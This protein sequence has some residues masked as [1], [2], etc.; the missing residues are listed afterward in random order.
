[1]CCVRTPSPLRVKI[2]SL[3]WFT[4]GPRGIKQPLNVKLTLYV[5]LLTPSPSTRPPHCRRGKVTRC[6]RDGNCSG[7]T[8]V[9]VVQSPLLLCTKRLHENGYYYYFPFGGVGRCFARFGSNDCWDYL[10]AWFIPVNFRSCWRLVIWKPISGDHNLFVEIYIQSLSRSWLLSGFQ[11]ILQSRN[12]NLPAVWD[13]A[14]SLSTYLDCIVSTS[15]VYLLVPC[16]GAKTRRGGAQKLHQNLRVKRTFCPK[17]VSIYSV[18]AVRTGTM[19][20]H[21]IYRS[22]VDLN[23][24]SEF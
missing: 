1:M 15:A 17:H 21:A 5:W 14:L 23:G 10:P 6:L 8:R 20:M 9:H 3:T 18:F 7:C 22:G 12:T 16:D 24:N 11:L 2:Y 13:M 19:G 4:E